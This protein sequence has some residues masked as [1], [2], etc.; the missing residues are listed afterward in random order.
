MKTR[1]VTEL[2]MII[3]VTMTTTMRVMVMAMMMMTTTTTTRRRKKTRR[4]KLIKKPQFNTDDILTTLDSHNI[5]ITNASHESDVLPSLVP[6]FFYFLIFCPI[7]VQGLHAG[8][9]RFYGCSM[10]VC[11]WG[12]GGEGGGGGATVQL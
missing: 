6:F 3:E 1:K 7:K 9:L 4:R 12:R 2:M 10:G 5:I 11:V 8:S